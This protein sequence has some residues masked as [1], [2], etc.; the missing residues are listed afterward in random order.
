[1]DLLADGCRVRVCAAL[2]Y[3]AMPALDNNT[4]IYNSIAPH[5]HIYIC[6][7]TYIQQQGSSSIFCEPR[8]AK[9]HHLGGYNRTAALCGQSRA[10]SSS[11]QTRLLLSR[12]I[13]ERGV[14]YPAMTPARAYIY[15]PSNRLKIHIYM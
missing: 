7:Y 8:R 15:I 12:T 2:V 14:Y 11:G 5:T 10:S 4:Y 13:S 6:V 3:I 1:M 9:P